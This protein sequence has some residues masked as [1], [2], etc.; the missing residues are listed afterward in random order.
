MR[1][2][3]SMT[4]VSILGI[5]R[6]IDSPATTIDSRG[7]TRAVSIVRV[8][9]LSFEKV[10]VRSPAFHRTSRLYHFSM[11][12]RPRDS[13]CDLPSPSTRLAVILEKSSIRGRFN[14]SERL[15]TEF[16]KNSASFGSIFLLISFAFLT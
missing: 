2:L 16:L 3:F 7:G 11:S 10:I 12:S 4:S 6:P 1:R 5:S 8:S 14:V 9:H 13:I 15:L